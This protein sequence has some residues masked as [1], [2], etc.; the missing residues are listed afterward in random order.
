MIAGTHGENRVQLLES[1]LLGLGKAEVGEDPAEKVPP[2]VPAESA[3]GRESF[4][5]RR[6]SEREDEVEAPCRGAG[7]G[8]AVLAD[9]ERLCKIM[10]SIFSQH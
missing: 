7:K 8:H 1:A 6:P 10:I 4:L 2:C 3:R 5:Q 9:V